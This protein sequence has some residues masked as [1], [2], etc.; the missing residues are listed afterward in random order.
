MGTNE[1]HRREESRMSEHYV[2]FGRLAITS[3]GQPLATRAAFIV[4]GDWFSAL[5][6]FAMYGLSQNHSCQLD[7]VGYV[8][9]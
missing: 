5:S 9:K 2:F 8:N 4:P 6:C 7:L 1:A 3:A